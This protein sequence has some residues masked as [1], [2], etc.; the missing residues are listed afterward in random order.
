MSKLCC[1]NILKSNVQCA[2]IC[3]V[4]GYNLQKLTLLNNIIA[5]DAT[6]YSELYIRL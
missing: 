2:I 1:V 4:C 5:T 6:Y 3:S